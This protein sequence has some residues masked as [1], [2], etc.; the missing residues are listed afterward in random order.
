[1][2][3]K[4]KIVLNGGKFFLKKFFIR[5]ASG[6]IN[7]IFKIGN[8]S[9]ILELWKK[10]ETPIFKKVADGNEEDLG[11]QLKY[12]IQ[13]FEQFCRNE[14]IPIKKEES[15]LKF[16]K[17]GLFIGNYT[18][19]ELKELIENHI[20]NN[21]ELYRAV[22][23]EN[24][25][26][27]VKKVKNREIGVGI[28]WTE[29][30]YKAISYWEGEQKEM[31]EIILVGKPME[32]DK[33]NPNEEINKMATI[34]TNYQYNFEEE[35]IRYFKG[36]LIFLEKMLVVKRIFN[37]VSSIY[38]DYYTEKREMERKINIGRIVKC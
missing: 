3:E 7:W 20:N 28:Y 2:E 34:I 15:F 13:D 25:N 6:N 33:I 18:L 11:S 21:L 26:G 37:R 32:A 23:V 10:R 22:C 24:V 9:K 31:R 8:L 4:K 17:K 30:I 16:C 36:G 1:M 35:E 19:Q 14:N 5:S 27:Y 12:L 38:E 29:N